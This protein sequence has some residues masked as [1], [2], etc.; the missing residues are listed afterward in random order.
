MYERNMPDNNKDCMYLGK[1]SQDPYDLGTK[2]KSE[3]V[4]RY[5]NETVAP[6]IA[7]EKQEQNE[8][9]MQNYKER[10]ERE[11]VEHREFVN[12]MHEKYIQYLKQ[13]NEIKIKR[14]KNPYLKINKNYIANDGKRYCDYDG[15][16]VLNGDI[17]RLRKMN[18]VGHDENGTY[19]YT[20]YVE[21]VQTEDDVEMLLKD[22]IPSG[23]PICF[24]SDKKIEEIIQSDNPNDLKSLL[25]LLSQ[26]EELTDDKEY[27]NYIGKIDKYNT[28]DKNIGNTTKTI[29]ST[30]KKLQQEFYQKKVQERQMK[31]NENQI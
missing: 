10:Q 13:Q 9:K 20:G 30:V 15:I 6:Q 12:K 5:I 4:K 27:L 18:R 19:I 1:L 22:G 24:A 14:M 23:M 25:A 16:N 26:S 11:N 17:L 3:T 21:S 2:N 7:R 28:M 8:R 29:Q 31:Q